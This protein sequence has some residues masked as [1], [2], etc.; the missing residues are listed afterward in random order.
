MIATFA[1]PDCAPSHADQLGSALE[2]IAYFEQNAVSLL[3]VPWELDPALTAD[4]R[5]VV[6]PSLREFQQGEELEG[7]H[8]FRCVQRYGERIGDPDYIEAHRLF[9][10]EE[11]RH[12]RDLAAFLERAGVTL[13]RERSLRNRLFCWCGSLGGLELTLTI[14]VCVE[15][16]AQSYYRAIRDATA[17]PLL[18]RLCTQILRDEHSHVRFHCERLRLMRR[19]RPRWRLALSRAFDRLLSYLAILIC[20]WGHAPAI[21]AGGY[22]FR[23]F[24]RE[25][26]TRFRRASNS[27][28]MG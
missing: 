26:Q 13:L 17:C 22:S 1:Q 15:A 18:R 11:R 8:F 23:R 12:G 2:W 27:S 6:L 9:M 10:A 3:D 20:W 24:A 14:I 5:A 25:V 4:E 16:V 28:V 7:G 21:R 19:D